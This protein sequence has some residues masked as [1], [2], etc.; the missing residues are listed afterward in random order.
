[1]IELVVIVC[2][3]N[4]PADC[5]DIHLTFAEDVTPTQCMMRG[6]PQIAK[7]IVEHGPAWTV[8]RWY[9]GQAGRRLK[10]I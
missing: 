1:M 7:W 10:D 5:K 2:L 4:S 9:C 3:A 6:Q 8:K